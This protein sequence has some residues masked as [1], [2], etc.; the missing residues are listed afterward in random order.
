M[1]EYTFDVPV[2]IYSNSQYTTVSM[3]SKMKEHVTM[4]SFWTME[5]YATD[6]LDIRLSIHRQ[7]LL[8][9]QFVDS[10]GI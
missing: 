1:D 6:E 8:K 9:N 3:F 10:S 4:C 5:L 2:S 7:Y